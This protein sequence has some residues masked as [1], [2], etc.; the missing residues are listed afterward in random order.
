MVEYLSTLLSEEYVQYLDT[1]LNDW[2][3]TVS[4]AVLAIEFIRQMILRTLTW[5]IIGDAVT[6][7]I[8]LAMFFGLRVL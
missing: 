3:F 8:T 6:N 7:Y 4:L 1:W 2:G 5:N